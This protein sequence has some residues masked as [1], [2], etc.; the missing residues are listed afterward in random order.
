MLSMDD[1]TI[2]GA[3]LGQLGQTAKKAGQ[4]IVKLP[5]EMSRDAGEQIGG[6]APLRQGSEEQA[7]QNAS[8][9]SKGWQSDEE[10][11]KFLKDLYGSA[12]Q[13]PSSGQNSLDKSASFAEASAAKPEEKKALLELRNQLH[14]ENYYDPTFNPPKKQE[15]ERP[16]EKVEMEKKQE[17]QDLQQKEAKKPSPL[18][19]QREQKKVEMFRGP[20]G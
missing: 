15:E 13:N 9:E 17:M 7:K 3:T 5:I 8:S 2:L 14:K 11:V 6:S 19:V 4:Q 20:A 10:R 1:S 16:A 18:A 12:K